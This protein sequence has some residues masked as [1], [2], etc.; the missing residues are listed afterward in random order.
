MDTIETR[1]MAGTLVEVRGVR[2][3][4]HKDSAADLLVLDNVDLTLRG[5]E[6][7]GLL[8]RSGSGKSTL[9][10]IVSGLLSPTAG[11]GELARRTAAGPGRRRGDGVPVLRP[12]PLA[13]QCRR[14]WSWGWRPRVSPG[15]S[16]RRAPRRRSTSSAWAATRAPTRRSCRVAC[17]S[18]SAWPAP[19]SCTP[20]CC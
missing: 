19:W 14:T 7:V 5:G 18:A 16:G 6:I 4:Y 9:L 11:L 12:V 8:G 3:S 2:Q 10:R 20:T 1:A 15:R 13:G 17:G